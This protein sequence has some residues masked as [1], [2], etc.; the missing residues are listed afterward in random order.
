MDL[1]HTEDCFDKLLNE[2]GTIMITRRYSWDID[3]I[4]RMDRYLSDREQEFIDI[5][6]LNYNKK[7]IIL[8]VGGGNGRHSRILIKKG[9]RIIAS[10]IDRIA[11]YELKEKDEKVPVIQT[12]AQYLPY[13]NE[14]FGCIMA[15]QMIDYLEN[16]NQFFNEINRILKKNGILL[17]TIG[18]KNSYKHFIRRVIRKKEE[19]KIFYR[20]SYNDVIRD[21]IEHEFKIENVW[22]YNWPPATRTSDTKLLT[23]FSLIEKTLNL[24]ARPSISPW[25]FIEAKRIG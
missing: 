13:K 25:V 8:D 15:I 1:R 18:N 9:F 23:I 14:S 24:A 20:S 10:D 17:V 11:L 6:M 19:D 21:L 5:S 2:R 7:N 4:T 12:D 16:N 22:G 3:G